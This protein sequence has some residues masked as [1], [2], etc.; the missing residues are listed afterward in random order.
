MVRFRYSVRDRQA[1]RCLVKMFKIS[2]GI[3]RWFVS[4]TVLEI[5]TF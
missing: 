2:R 5:V 1:L 4:S 3:Y